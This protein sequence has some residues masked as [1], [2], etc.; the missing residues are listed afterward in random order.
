VEIR[1]GVSAS[2]NGGK[3]GEGDADKAVGNSVTVPGSMDIVSQRECF[4]RI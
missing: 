3:G 4:V 2:E 1:F